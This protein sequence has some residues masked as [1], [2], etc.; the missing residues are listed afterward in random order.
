MSPGHAFSKSLVS[1]FDG[2]KILKFFVADPGSGASLIEY[3]G[4]KISDPGWKI[5]DPG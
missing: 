1:I 5:S 3:P 2:F 4:W